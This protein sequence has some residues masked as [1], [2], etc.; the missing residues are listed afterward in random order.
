MET[1]DSIAR[2]WMVL[3]ADHTGIS[4]WSDLLPENLNQPKLEKSRKGRVGDEEEP[5][6]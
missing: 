5:I 1:A 4:V 3:R 6:H 2:M